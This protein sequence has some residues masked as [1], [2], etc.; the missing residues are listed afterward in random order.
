MILVFLNK[1]EQ[2]VSHQSRQFKE[3][4]TTNGRPKVI[5]DE[6]ISEFRIIILEIMKNILLHINI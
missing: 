1:I 4:K 3:V 5:F 6:M 2:S